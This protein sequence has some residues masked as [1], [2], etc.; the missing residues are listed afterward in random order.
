MHNPAGFS[1]VDDGIVLD[2][3]PMKGIRVDP[4]EQLATALPGQLRAMTEVKE[5]VRPRKPLPGQPEHPAG[6]L[7][8]LE[9]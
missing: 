4:A 9:V 2:L 6:R 1:V 5:E 8:R 7:S 3:S